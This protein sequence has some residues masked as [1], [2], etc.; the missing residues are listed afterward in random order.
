MRIGPL[1]IGVIFAISRIVA[2]RVGQVTNVAN[3]QADWQSAFATSIEIC[4]DVAPA[5]APRQGL[6]SCPLPPDVLK[7]RNDHQNY[8]ELLDMLKSI[9]QTPVPKVEN[10]EKD[11]SSTEANANEREEILA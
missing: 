9:E 5:P 11:D 8:L 6:H 2:R 7:A 10:L 3:L 1:L 4:D